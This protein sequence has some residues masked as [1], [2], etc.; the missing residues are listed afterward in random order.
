MSI[1]AELITTKDLSLYGSTIIQITPADFLITVDGNIPVRQPNEI[2]ELVLTPQSYA[3]VGG[4]GSNLITITGY[5]HINSTSYSDDL[6][7]VHP[8]LYNEDLSP[9][10]QLNIVGTLTSSVWGMADISIPILYF[11]AV[12]PPTID[13][14]RIRNVLRSSG[15]DYGTM[16]SN[17]I[18]NKYSKVIV[19]T[20]PPFQP[21]SLIGYTPNAIGNWSL[22]KDMPDII[23]TPWTD[24]TV[25]ISTIVRRLGVVD[26]DIT[27]ISIEFP[28]G[29]PVSL[30]MNRSNN[31][32]TRVDNFPTGVY[33][34]VLRAQKNDLSLITLG[35]VQFNVVNEPSPLS[36]SNGYFTIISYEKVSY[37]MTIRNTSSNPITLFAKAHIIGQSGLNTHDS[38]LIP[39]GVGIIANIPPN[40]TDSYIFNFF[41][42]FP[43]GQYTVNSILFKLGNANI[44]NTYYTD[45]YQS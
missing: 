25:N 7:N 26:Q 8:N 27:G 12:Y 29:G 10:R 43:S 14:A 18:V 9:I 20:I 1:V 35:S 44:V 38:G 4:D 32:L 6:N 40:S 19:P 15:T 3:S 37:T 41:T 11:P 39:S 16:F 23:T 13:V 34:I 45:E 17:A 24:D 42:G 28:H 22:I 30:P 31:R 5:K 33:S 2:F 21:V 36:Y